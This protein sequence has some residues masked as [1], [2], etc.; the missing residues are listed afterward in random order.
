MASHVCL[1]TDSE[2]YDLMDAEKLI[3]SKNSFFNN[4]CLGDG[5]AFLSVVVFCTIMQ[6]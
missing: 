5:F 6:N 4:M 1:V 2:E 3:L